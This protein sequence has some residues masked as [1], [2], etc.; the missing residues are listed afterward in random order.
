M[1]TQK[2]QKTE[3]SETLKCRTFGENFGDTFSETVGSN[4]IRVT[5]QT[6]QTA[7]APIGVAHGYCCCE[8]SVGWRQTSVC[9][10]DG[11]ERVGVGEGDH[12]LEKSEEISLIKK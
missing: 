9:T 8:W 1:H 11:D 7:S 12:L 4:V 5:Q 10:W 3:N 2:E 6:R